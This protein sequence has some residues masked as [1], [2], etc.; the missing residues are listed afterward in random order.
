MCSQSRLGDQLYAL[1]LCVPYCSQALNDFVI[2]VRSLLFK[3]H[4]EEDIKNQ[5]R[6]QALARF[7]GAITKYKRSTALYTNIPERY[8]AGRVTRNRGPCVRIR[9]VD[10]EVL[11]FQCGTI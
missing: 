1:K 8:L 2:A 10:L 5:L 4:N 9:P 6:T 3:W 11:E 7:A